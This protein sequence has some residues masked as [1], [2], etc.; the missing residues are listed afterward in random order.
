MKVFIKIFCTLFLLI[1]VVGFSQ[2]PPKPRPVKV[3]PISVS[4]DNYRPKKQ[5]KPLSPRDSIQ[6]E[7]RDVVYLGYYDWNDDDEQEKIDPEKDMI[8]VLRKKIAETKGLR[9]TLFRFYLANIYDSYISEYGYRIT[10]TDITPLEKLPEDYK[11]W[12]IKDFDREIDRLY[13]EALSD[14]KNLQNE[15]VELWKTL[16]DDTEFAKYKPTLYD[17]VATSYLQFLEKQPFSAGNEN[18]KK[19]EFIKKEL[20]DFHANDTDK[21]A[22]LYLKSTLIKGNPEE[23]AKAYE[24]LADA[25]LNEP[26]SAYLLEQA[27]NLAK[28]ENSEKNL[29][30]AHRI[31]TKAI[32]KVPASDWQN[33]CKILINEI[34]YKSLSIEIPERSLPGEYI[35]MKTTHANTNEVKIGISKHSKNRNFEKEFFWRNGSI[36][37]G[38]I[39][40][41]NSNFYH[42]NFR[43]DDFKLKKFDDYKT[44]QT[45]LAIPPLEE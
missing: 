2:I 15:K 30:N 20:T 31:C 22:I 26:F 24:N 10:K 5:G 25:Y 4:D 18:E 42:K 21:T 45:T 7:I 16:I 12:A 41:S 17:F 19:V 3:K 13:T 36:N 40:E 23:Q 6:D 35:P 1:F 11:S 32:D 8:L 28:Q 9:K 29:V 34:E 38:L 33:H 27:A 44:H 14:K 43:T 39:N 37:Q